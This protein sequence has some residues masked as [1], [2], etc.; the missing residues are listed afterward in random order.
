MYFNYLLEG[1]KAVE[2]C[3]KTMFLCTCH[4]LSHFSADFGGP[5]LNYARCMTF[6]D[7][8]PQTADHTL[9]IVN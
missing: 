7:C 4:H 8:R 2:M 9:Q 5:Y 3:L 1:S 6:A